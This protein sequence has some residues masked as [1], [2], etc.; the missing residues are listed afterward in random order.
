MIDWT[1]RI[2]IEPLFYRI[3]REKVKFLKPSNN[4]RKTRDTFDQMVVEKALE[5]N[6]TAEQILSHIDK[7]KS[8][9]KFNLNDLA[10]FRELKSKT[11]E[12]SK[13]FIRWSTSFIQEVDRLWL[14]HIKKTLSG[15]LT[16]QDLL[17][18]EKILVDTLYTVIN[19]IVDIEEIKRLADTVSIT[20]DSNNKVVFC[21]KHIANIKFSEIE[22]NC[23]YFNPHKEFE[24]YMH[25]K[26]VI[27]L[28]PIRKIWAELQA[29]DW[30]VNNQV[31]TELNSQTDLQIRH[32]LLLANYKRLLTKYGNQKD[33]IK[34]FL[35]QEVLNVDKYR[36]PQKGMSYETI[37]KDVQTLFPKG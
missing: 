24:A 9:K 16:N 32:K 13:K 18:F 12:A 28:Q 11:D 6:T 26:D 29:Y 34:A 25:N 36:W 35:R 1:E 3:S 2:K 27:L 10:K 8:N 37:K 15:H 19:R 21:G 31:S 20:T 17:L 23:I 22:V 5:V 30:Y 7:L 4:L 14:P 33:A